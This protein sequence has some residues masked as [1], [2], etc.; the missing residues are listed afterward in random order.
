MPPQRHEAARPRSAWT[1]IQGPRLTRCVTIRCWARPSA[2]LVREHGDPLAR[3]L[4][5]VTHLFPTA[6]ALASVD[7]ESFRMPRSRARTLRALSDSLA[8]GEIVLAR[9]GDL[10]RVRAQLLALPGIGPWTADYVVM[11]A[12]GDTDVFLATDLGI[13]RSLERLGGG[14]QPASG[15]APGAR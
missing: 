14:G 4:G 12:L 1:P 10:E 3:P 9:G 7:P 6:A 5:T 15:P 2:R 11:R 8:S 13:K